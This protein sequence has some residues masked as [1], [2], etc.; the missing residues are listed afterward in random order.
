[1]APSL[2]HLHVCS[3]DHRARTRFRI[4]SEVFSR[5]LDTRRAGGGG[6]KDA[7]RHLPRLKASTRQRQVPRNRH[8]QNLTRGVLIC[9]DPWV[10]VLTTSRRWIMNR[11]APEPTLDSAQSL[12]RCS[13]Y[14]G[15]EAT[16]NQFRNG[17]S[18]SDHAAGSSL[19]PIQGVAQL[20]S[21]APSGHALHY[22]VG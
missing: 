21:K 11:E 16:E 17:G 6:Q 3:S 2:D 1:M 18:H 10:R 12:D 22:V 19:L 5:A 20:A 7:G 13:L 14:A 15:H 9:G 4:F 8:S